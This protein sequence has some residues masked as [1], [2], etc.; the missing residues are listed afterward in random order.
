MS[1]RTLA[2]GAALLGA[3]ALGPV[4]VAGAQTPQPAAASTTTKC[5]K[6]EALLAKVQQRENKVNGRITALEARVAKLR[7]AGKNARADALQKRVDA[8]K[9]RVAKV[10]ARV[11]K[12]EARLEAKCKTAAAPA[13][14]SQAS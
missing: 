1:V 13:N 10:E 14:G 4:T 7:Q 6:A 11:T 12:L 8:L 3:M 9:D 2:A 5:Q